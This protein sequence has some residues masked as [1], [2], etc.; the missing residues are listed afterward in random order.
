MSIRPLA[1][2]LAVSL[3]ALP[4]S[5]CGVVGGLA[6]AIKEGGKEMN[7]SSSSSSSSSQQADNSTA[8]SAPREVDPPPAP[9]AAPRDSITVET[10]K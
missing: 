7:K 3:L 1:L 5:G 10:L 9:A 6:Y 2:L 8:A 4:L